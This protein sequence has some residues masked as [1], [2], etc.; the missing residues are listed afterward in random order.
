MLIDE[1]KKAVVLSKLSRN[2]AIALSDKLNNII[3]TEEDIKSIQYID[4]FID[5]KE[6]KLGFRVEDVDISRVQTRLTNKE[7]GLV[8]YSLVIWLIT[9]EGKIVALTKNNHKCIYDVEEVKQGRKI[10]IG[11]YKD[12]ISDIEYLCY[13]INTR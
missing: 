9:K 12:Y 8:K 2:S 5:E 6:F 4:Y 13:I 7:Y 3:F 10:D 1:H 11:S